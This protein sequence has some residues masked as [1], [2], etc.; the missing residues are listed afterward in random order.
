MEEKLTESE[1]IFYKGVTKFNSEMNILSIFHTI[2]KLK[3]GMCILVEA[4]PEKVMDK[5]K[6]M[7][8]KNS[9]LY[10]DELD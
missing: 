3:A 8:F 1:L 5:I 7:Y 4:Q 6:E 10:I 2:Q 9:T